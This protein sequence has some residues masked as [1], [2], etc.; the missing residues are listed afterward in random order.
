MLITFVLTKS[1]AGPVKKMG[2]LLS[3]LADGGADL[4]L[5]L[6]DRGNDEIARMGGSFNQFMESLTE[7]VSQL[8]G[9]VSEGVL[10]VKPFKRLPNRNKKRLLCYATDSIG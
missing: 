1:I 5:R 9:T 4:A 8:S 6:P 2:M 3:S 7:M 10:L